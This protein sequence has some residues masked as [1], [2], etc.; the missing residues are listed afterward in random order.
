MGHA[1][2]ALALTIA[3]VFN[4][5]VLTILLSKR[6]GDLE[7]SRILFT[8]FRMIPGLVVMALVVSMLL[9]QVN[10]MIPGDFWIRLGLLG[11][12]VVCGALVYA[13]SLRVCGVAEIAQAWALFAKKLSF[14]SRQG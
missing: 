1:G 9:G 14:P 7:L 3:S 2:L 10:W 11:S 12:S 5:I 6:I 8:A 13:V 4:A